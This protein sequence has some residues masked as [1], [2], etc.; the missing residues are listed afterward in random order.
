VRPEFG[1]LFGRGRVVKT[2]QRFPIGPAVAACASCFDFFAD[3]TSD[4]A[5]FHFGAY[6]SKCKKRTP[7]GAFARY[8]LR[9]SIAFGQKWHLALS[10]SNSRFRWRSAAL[11]DGA[12]TPAISVLSAVKGVKV[13]AP[14]LA[15]AVVPLTV[16]ILIGLFAVQKRAR[17]SSGRC[18][19]QSC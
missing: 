5:A 12:I 2:L 18:S 10:P 4:C 19:D 9:A 14:W 7:S 3:R 13:D 11:R 6:P 15:P 17:A 8:A 16:L 1:F